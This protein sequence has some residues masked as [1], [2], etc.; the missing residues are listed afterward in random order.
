MHATTFCQTNPA[1]SRSR[2][3]PTFNA[4]SDRE[5]IISSS[6]RTEKTPPPKNTGSMLRPCPSSDDCVHSEREPSAAPKTETSPKLDANSSQMT[7]TVIVVDKDL[8]VRKGLELLIC[9]HGWRVQTFASAEQFL[10]QPRVASPCCLVLDVTLPDL[11]GLDL[12]QRVSDRADMP[13]IF[14]T[15]ETDVQTSVRAMKAGALDYLTKPLPDDVLLSAI[16]LGLERSR[17]LLST[18]MAARRVRQCY[19]SLTRREREIMQLVISGWMNKQIG[20]ALSLCEITVKAHRGRMKRKMKA[21]SL[22]ELV[23]MAATVGL[24]AVPRPNGHIAYSPRWQHEN[25]EHAPS[26]P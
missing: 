5:G 12:Q 21:K 11:N 8:A 17:A 18:A 14:F 16:R 24:P 15:A 10:A 19:A 25:V 22:P 23:T 9:A 4:A 26:T 2:L 7:P 3:Q 1:A 6:L 13:V 20:A